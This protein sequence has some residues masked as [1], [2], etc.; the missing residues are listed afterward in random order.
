MQVWTG[1]MG[2]RCWPRRLRGAGTWRGAE[3][4]RAS[5]QRPGAHGPAVAQRK[6]ASASSSSSGRSCLAI[7]AARARPEHG[8]AMARGP[9]SWRSSRLPG[10]GTDA[11]E[12]DVVVLCG[13]VGARDPPRGLE[14]FRRRREVS[15]L[16][17]GPRTPS[18]VV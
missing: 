10:P 12:T 1:G 4:A 15:G 8:K 5:G 13:A 9:M 6:Q 7:P 14:R 18:R 11:A 16:G 17:R 3:D 2:A